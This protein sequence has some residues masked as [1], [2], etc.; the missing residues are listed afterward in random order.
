MWQRRQCECHIPPPNVALVAVQL[1]Q[2]NL[3]NHMHCTA[4]RKR[5][6]W[7]CNFLLPQPW[8]RLQCCSNKGPLGP[9]ASATTATFSFSLLSKTREALT[10]LCAHRYR[11]TQRISTP[12]LVAAK[13]LKSLC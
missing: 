10:L 7:H 6:V 9:V 12:L 11:L 1:S 2:C 5:S 4:L 3:A 8:E 13:S